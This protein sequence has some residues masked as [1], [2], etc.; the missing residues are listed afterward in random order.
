[1]RKV[2]VMRG[3]PG[4]GKSTQVRKIIQAP[5]PFGSSLGVCSAD[6]FFVGP[7]GVYRFDASKLGEAHKSC[8]KRFLEFTNSNFN[9]IVVDNTNINPMDAVPYVAVAEALGYDVEIVQVDCDPVV[10]ASRNVHGV[11]AAKIKEM[12][13]RLQ[14]IKPPKHWKITHVNPQNPPSTV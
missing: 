7:D 6:Y 8:L 5:R 3:I 1:M 12:A 2:T 9:H 14:K 10:A 4:S 13:D 11:P